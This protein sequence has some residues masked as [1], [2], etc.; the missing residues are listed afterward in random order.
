MTKKIMGLFII[1]TLVISLFTF[2]SIEAAS[3][4]IVEPPPSGGTING[5]FIKSTYGTTQYSMEIEDYYLNS[6]EGAKFA[7]KNDVSTS[8]GF[9]YFS[10]TWI[11]GVGPYISVYTFLIAGERAEVSTQIRK[12][13]D[14]HKP[15]HLTVFK[16]KYG[17][18]ILVSA[19]DGKGS[20]V[21]PY[22]A[23]Q[24]SLQ[25]IVSRKYK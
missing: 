3:N 16:D 5:A 9:A 11:P 23:P 13:T 25:K 7:S 12:Y 6:K 18:H 10:A 20:S 1:S 4:K 14:N 21:K 19:W 8:E 17:R 2:N 15:V 22:S 24:P